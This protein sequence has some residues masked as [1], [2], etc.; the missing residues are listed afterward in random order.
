MTAAVLAIR[1]VAVGRLEALPPRR[2]RAVRVGDRRIALFRTGD[3]RLFA[4]EDR[5]PHRGG[6]L[7]EGIVH[8][9]CVTCPLHD[10]VIDLAEGRAV[11]PDEGRVRTYPVRV[12]DGRIEI[13][14]GTAP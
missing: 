12:V 3:D 10:W 8:G 7:S 13:G 14:L 5:C 1:W 6:P 11:P 2:G 4:V 9:H